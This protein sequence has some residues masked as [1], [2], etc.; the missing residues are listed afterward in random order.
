MAPKLPMLFALLFGVLHAVFV[1]TTI[2]P[3]GTSG[4][5]A[6]WGFLLYDFPLHWLVNN[7]NWGT[8][9]RYD[10][11]RHYVLFFSIVGTLMYVAF[12]FCLGAM[13]KL[14]LRT[15]RGEWR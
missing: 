6:A 2:V 15:L 10:S 5:S 11:G 12:G 8:P 7:L 14:L 9:F 4:E 1:L 3:N 13:L